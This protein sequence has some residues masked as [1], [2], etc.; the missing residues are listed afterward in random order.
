MTNR[1]FCVAMMI[2]GLVA[3]AAKGEDPQ[4]LF[5]QLYGDEAK[6]VANAPKASATPPTSTKPRGR[7]TARACH[8]PS[9][10][11]ISCFRVTIT[12]R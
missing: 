3:V 5:D 9:A 7:S 6:K 12:S 10:L 1:A 2:L 4:K 11:T 8:T